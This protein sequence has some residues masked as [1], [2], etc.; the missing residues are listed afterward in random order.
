MEY[1]SCAQPIVFTAKIMLAV[2][3]AFRH[4]IITMELA[5]CARITV[6]TVQA[7]E[8]V[9]GVFMDLCLKFQAVFLAQLDVLLV[10][11]N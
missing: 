4:I 5:H 11:L 2:C 1:V 9:W 7:Q 10:I 8:P 6:I 3:P